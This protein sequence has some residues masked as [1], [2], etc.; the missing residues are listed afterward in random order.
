MPKPPASCPMYIIHIHEHTH[1]G[2]GRVAALVGDT[3]NTHIT[4]IHTYITYTHTYREKEVY[5]V[6][7]HVKD[8]RALVLVSAARERVHVCT[9][10]R[11]CSLIHN[12]FSYIEIP[13]RERVHDALAQRALHAAGRAQPSRSFFARVH[14]PTNQNTDMAWKAS[15]PSQPVHTRT[16]ALEDLVFLPLRQCVLLPPP[17]LRRPISCSAFSLNPKH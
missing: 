1:T 5:R 7:A 15:H 6:G 4:Y 2:F 9:C 11:M 3:H 8:I 17:P 16:L 13:A 12:M 14:W 10:V